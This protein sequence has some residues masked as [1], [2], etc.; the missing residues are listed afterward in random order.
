ML[1][2]PT[3]DPLPRFLTAPVAGSLG[4]RP[5]AIRRRVTSGLW[6]RLAPGLYLTRPDPPSRSDWAAAG[7]LLAGRGAALSG[8][9]GV[10]LYGIGA[11]DPPG[12]DVLVLA[13]HGR[14]RK[15]G[16]ILIRPS[17]RIL[18]P[19]FRA[20]DGF[21]VVHVAPAARAVA[22]TAL[23]YET[24]AP[25]R[26][27][28]TSAVQ[29][30]L[31]SVDEL[32]FEYETGPRNDSRQL[33]TAVDDILAGAQSIAEAELAECLRL[34]NLPPFEMN[35]WLLDEYGTRIAR[36]DALWRSLGAVLEVDS[37]THHFDDEGDWEGTMS[38]HNLLSRLGLV[39][40]HYSPKQIR[41][42]GRAIAIE[43]EAWLRRRAVELGC[44]YPP[45]ATPAP[46]LG[47]PLTLPFSVINS[48][49]SL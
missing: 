20:L 4:Y 23:L 17:T 43:V 35:I 19:N 39:V 22:D 8:W 25:A 36:A 18:R 40:V 45:P 1:T 42:G 9:D 47:T 11:D 13:R 34:E 3:G 27:L 32:V 30:R 15:V 2:T 14:H 29:R 37:R 31:C 6:Q 38:R 46:V 12:E 24:L 7:L 49:E 10:R 16:P 5:G 44:P 48:A 26:A 28:V 41:R 21:G 33:H